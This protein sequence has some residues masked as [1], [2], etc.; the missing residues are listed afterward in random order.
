MYCI[1]KHKHAY[2]DKMTVTYISVLFIFFFNNKHITSFFFFVR[3]LFWNTFDFSRQFL[4]QPF[5]CDE[6]EDDDDITGH[7]LARD[8]TERGAVQASYYTYYYYYYLCLE[9][10]LRRVGRCITI[11]YNKI[12][13]W[14][15][16]FHK[17]DGPFFCSGRR[18]S[19][20]CRDFYYNMMRNILHKWDI[21]QSVVLL[22]L[23][24]S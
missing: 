19:W 5:L 23:V 17:W 4:C 15:F 9:C 21:I 24:L 3:A 7:D 13:E 12:S 14:W 11:H 22:V 1:C 2:I 6:N 8:R 16:V 20:V 10:M 18:N